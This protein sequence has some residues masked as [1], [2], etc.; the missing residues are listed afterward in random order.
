M[1]ILTIALIYLVAYASLAMLDMLTYK[2]W[3]STNIIGI[4]MVIC[5]R[6]TYFKWLV[7]DVWGDSAQYLGYMENIMCTHQQHRRSNKW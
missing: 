4:V 3:G 2:K 5:D 1:E 6:S 7:W